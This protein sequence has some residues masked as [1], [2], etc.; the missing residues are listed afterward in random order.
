MSEKLKPVR[1]KNTI[2]VSGYD[3][4]NNSVEAEE[5][6]TASSTFIRHCR[7][8]NVSLMAQLLTTKMYFRCLLV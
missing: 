1:R 3:A 7:I 8:R 5:F 4:V 2:A 6:Q